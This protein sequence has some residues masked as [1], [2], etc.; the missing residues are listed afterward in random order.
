MTFDGASATL[1][2]VKGF[3]DLA[4][5]LA[6]PEVE[7]HCT[8]LMGVPERGEEGEP[9]IDEKARRDY[10]A[11][12]R[13]LNASIIEAD[14]MND[15]GRKETLG[16][17]LDQLTDHL[18]TVLGLGGR[19]RKVNRT[20]DRARSAVTWRIRSAIR[21]IQTV[22]PSLANHLSHA[23]RTGTFCCYAPEKEHFWQL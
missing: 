17:E 23:I 18:S 7:I 10:E 3:H 14:A 12:I 5:L 19:T 9:V 15:L 22:H 16:E 2:Y 21:K 6:Q 4:R 1:P 11:R 13:D 8:E 20:A